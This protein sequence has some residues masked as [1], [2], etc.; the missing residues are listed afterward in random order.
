VGAS[1][2]AALQLGLR[3][4]LPCSVATLR[5]TILQ[6]RNASGSRAVPP[7]LLLCVLWQEG[8]GLGLRSIVKVG[9][10]LGET[11]LVLGHALLRLLEKPLQNMLSGQGPF[12]FVDCVLCRRRWVG[13]LRIDC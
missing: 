3:A 2:A 13:T 5:K 11:L 8:G 12:T 10:I 4:C 9:G 7:L 1:S 6:E